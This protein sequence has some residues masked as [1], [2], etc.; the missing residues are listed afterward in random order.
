MKFPINIGNI[1][2]CPILKIL[3]SILSN[4][5]N[6]YRIILNIFARHGLLVERGAISELPQSEYYL[7]N[8]VN[9]N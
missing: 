5:S 2:Y 3:V 8:N 7:I 6:I 9:Y 4:A 1:E